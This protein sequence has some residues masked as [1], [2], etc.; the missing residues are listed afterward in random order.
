MIE[1]NQL[2]TL[3]LNDQNNLF[4]HK[5]PLSYQKSKKVSTIIDNLE[6]L[7]K[8]KSIILILFLYCLTIVLLKIEFKQKRFFK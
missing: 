7:L 5:D 6:S 2:G 8:S 1:L 3:G 4:I